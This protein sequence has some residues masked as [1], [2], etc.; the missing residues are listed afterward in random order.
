MSKP[1]VLIADSMS[2]QALSVFD[3]RGVEAL[4]SG[5]LSAEE[6]MDPIGDF[7]GLAIRSTTSLTAELLDRARHPKVVGRAGIGVDNVDIPA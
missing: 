3:D 5:K 6:L 1:R 4:Q 2:S 7:D